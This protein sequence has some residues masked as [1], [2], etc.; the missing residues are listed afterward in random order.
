MRILLSVFF[1]S[2]S[3]V[4]LAQNQQANLEKYWRYRERLRQNFIVI[5]SQVEDQGVNMPATAVRFSSDDGSFVDW[6]DA[7]NGMS[8][9][10]SVLATELWLLKSNK[11]DYSQT[12]SELY[13]AMLAMERLDLYSEYSLRVKNGMPPYVDPA[14]DINGFHIRDDVSQE[15]FDAN[16]GHFDVPA[17]G[18]RYATGGMEESSQDN[19]FHNMEGFA[20]VAKLLG[21]E[22]VANV[23][24]TFTN[25]YIP[26][27]LSAQGIMSGTNIDFSLWAKDFVKR[28]VK[29][30]QSD[31]RTY[32]MPVPLLP[33][34][35]YTDHWILRNKVTH[36]YVRE[37]SGKDLDLG[38]FYNVGV[39]KAGN[40]I[41]G[42]SLRTEDAFLVSNLKA[43]AIYLEMFNLGGDIPIIAIPWPSPFDLVFDPISLWTYSFDRYKISTLAT[44]GNAAD[45]LTF[46]RLREDRDDHHDQP[47]EHFPLLYTV[48]NDPSRA[49]MYPENGIYNTDRARIENLLNQAPDCG[50]TSYGNHQWSSDS[51]LVWPERLGDHQ[52]YNIEYSGLDYMMLHNLYYIAFRLEDFSNAVFVDSHFLGTTFYLYGNGTYTFTSIDARN[53]IP[54]T[55]NATYRA[56]TSIN[57][58]PGFQAKAG[59]A[60]HTEIIPPRPDNYQGFDYKSLNVA[61]CGGLVNSGGRVA[62]TSTPATTTNSTY[63]AAKYESHPEV[64]RALETIEVK[65]P[66]DKLQEY[67]G[68]DKLV[69]I[70]PNPTQ[71]DLHVTFPRGVEGALHFDVIDINGKV[72][73]S[74]P[75]QNQDFTFDT[76]SLGTGIYILKAYFDNGVTITNKFTVV[77]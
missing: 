47:Y 19:I 77:R 21:T 71:G 15:F 48:L 51:R 73:L 40:N 61:Q 22:S 6:G 56:T 10:L 28:Y 17:V 18:S 52:A 5:S 24:I 74:I 58:K 1:L 31:G 41:T 42:E 67:L 29:Y 45:I 59:C 55:G 72:V 25:S 36:D 3:L 14:T 23:P 39:I 69:V 43:E 30:M 66:P 20:L 32:R 2:C 12:L 13:Y 38:I 65:L 4:G 76:A 54:S 7:N 46:Y 60:F 35:T 11:Q 50:P 26:G 53:I 33:D 63:A 37:G 9:Y 27:Y 70:Y 62:T 8:H 49:L 16:A 34:I 57:L 64:P 75:G 44:T 68:A